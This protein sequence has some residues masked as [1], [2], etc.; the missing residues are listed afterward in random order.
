MSCIAL[1][2]QSPQTGT[3]RRT[4]LPILLL[5]IAL[6]CAGSARS[7]AAQPSKHQ[8]TPRQAH[9]IV[10]LVARHDQIDLSDTHIEL[11]SMDLSSDFTPGFFS[12]IVIRESTSPGPD[13]TLRRYAINRR[14]GDVWE[15]TL[16]THYD[17][18]ELA[19]L[20]H[21]YSGRTGTDGSELSAQGKRLGCSQ[22]LSK[23]TS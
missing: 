14:T 7:H 6:A 23:P 18:P 12:F 4:F 13:E 2:G 21:A 17:F 5:A 20:Q 3:M 10:A 15:M 16:C 8:I 9:Q 22:Q 19:R 11:N 1:A